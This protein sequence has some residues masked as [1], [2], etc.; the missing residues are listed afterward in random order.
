[1]SQNRPQN[2]A[3]AAPDAAVPNGASEPLDPSPPQPIMATVGA[4]AGTLPSFGDAANDGAGGRAAPNGA[5]AASLGIPATRG[6]QSGFARES[7]RERRI[8]DA[9]FKRAALQLYRMHDFLVRNGVAI[10][11]RDGAA[12][13]IGGGLRLGELNTL[14]FITSGRPATADEWRLLEDKQGELLS[15]FTADLRR[16]YWN[17]ASASIINTYP[18][19]FLLIAGMALAMSVFPPEW[20]LFQGTNANVA[21][22]GWRFGGFLLWTLSLGGLGATTFLAVNTL[23]IQS[24]ATFDLGDRALVRMRIKLGALFGTVVALPIAYGPFV[25]FTNSVIADPNQISASNSAL[26]LAPFLLGFS[27]SLVLAVLARLVAG[28]EAIFGVTSAPSGRTRS[29]QADTDALRAGVV[30][31]TRGAASLRG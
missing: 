16:K 28:V 29:A 9:R 31:D 5:T 3:G 23:S 30:A 2:E 21:Q 8:K 15:A 22:H 20:H 10:G 11:A 12:S 13:V 4:D 7:T 27:T 25:D 26:L 1:M 24:D 6:Q 14:M 17:E 18:Y 19:A